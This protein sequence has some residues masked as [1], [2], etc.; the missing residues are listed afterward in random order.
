MQLHFIPLLRNAKPCVVRFHPKD[1]VP[2]FARTR[3]VK[4]L[5]IS[6]SIY[7]LRT[8]NFHCLP[9]R[10]SHYYCP[11]AA[12]SRRHINKPS[13]YALAHTVHA[14]NCG[15]SKHNACTTPTHITTIIIGP[16]TF[17]QPHKTPRQTG[18]LRQ[19]FT[20]AHNVVE[21]V[22]IWKINAPTRSEDRM[23]KLTHRPEST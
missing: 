5:P 13:L 23:H 2:P 8:I 12:H 20:A 17:R 11:A 21:N 7:I 4:A 10:H 3:Y 18:R 1:N 16:P 19:T 22:Y 6:I 9:H 15:L 14:T